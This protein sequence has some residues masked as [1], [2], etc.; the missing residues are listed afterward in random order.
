MSSVRSGS[1]LCRVI[2]PRPVS[3][4]KHC[5]SAKIVCC[6]FILTGLQLVGLNP[7]SPNSDQH[8]FSPKKIHRL[9]R[10]KS[11]R[12]NKMITKGKVFDLKSNSLNQFLRKINVWISV[13]RICIWILCNSYVDDFPVC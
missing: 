1:L 5:R 7:L 10:A 2:D 13:W 6:L 8:Q 11:M 12:I 9:S 4:L 3:Y